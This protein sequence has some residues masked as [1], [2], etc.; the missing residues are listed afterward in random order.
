MLQYVGLDHR[1]ITLAAERSPQKWGLRTVATNIPIVSEE[2]SRA[3]RPD[4]Y[5]VLPWHFRDSFVRRE[6]AYLRSGGRMLFPLPEPVV[7]GHADGTSPRAP[8]RAT[9]M[10]TAVRLRTGRS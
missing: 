3:A 10:P 4:Y 8:L 1:H 7:V 9:D 6:Q 5:F 2:V